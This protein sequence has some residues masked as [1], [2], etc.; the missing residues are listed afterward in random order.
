MKKKIRKLV[1]CNYD[2]NTPLSFISQLPDEIKVSI[3]SWQSTLSLK[4]QPLFITHIIEKKKG[5]L[6]AFMMLSFYCSRSSLKDGDI[7]EPSIAFQ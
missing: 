7:Q 1:N 2:Q 3:Y 5:V 6:I 4:W